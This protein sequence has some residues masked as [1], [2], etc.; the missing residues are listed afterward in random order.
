MICPKVE[1]LL[2][3]SLL[4]SNAT[5]VFFWFS[6]RLHSTRQ[7]CNIVFPTVPLSKV[8]QR[9]LRSRLKTP[10]WLWLGLIH[11]FLRVSL[12]LIRNLEPLYGNLPRFDPKELALKGSYTHCLIAIS[13]SWPNQWKFQD[14]KMEVLYHIRPYFVGIFPYI[15]LT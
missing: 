5:R 3:E 2:G 1:P 12:Q 7:L 6:T 14:P 10:L 8:L 15:A 11:C 4:E 13:C 9:N